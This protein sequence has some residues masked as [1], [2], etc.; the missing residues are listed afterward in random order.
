MLDLF[1]SRKNKL[2]PS[3]QEAL[4]ETAFLLQQMMNKIDL[5]FNELSSQIRDVELGLKEMEVRLL[6][7]DLKDK[8]QYGLLHYKLHEKEHKNLQEEIEGVEVELSTKKR[9]TREQ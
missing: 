6:T 5:R 3:Q 9:P 7:K 8:Q 2:N 1:K 4:N